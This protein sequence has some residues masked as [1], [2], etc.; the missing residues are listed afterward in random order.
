MVHAPA[1]TA[2]FSPVSYRHVKLDQRYDAI[3]IGSGAGGLTTAVLLAKHAHMRVLV[4]ERHYTAGGFTH[5]FRRPGFEW[6]VGVHY[7]GQTQTGSDGRR[8]F[9]HLTDARLQWAP[10]PDVYDRIFI[11]DRCYDFLSGTDRFRE[12]LKGYFPGDVQAIDRYVASV[13]R[14]VRLVGGFFAEKM[15]PPV[16]SRILGQALRWPYLRYAGRTT[17]SVIG[18]LTHNRELISVLTG[19]WGD[20]GLPPGQSSF[21]IHAILAKHYFDG[22]GYPVGGA[23]AILDSMG[24]A[25]QNAGGSVVVGAEVD[26]I[27]VHRNRTEGVRMVDGR[28]IR[29]NVVISDAGAGNTYYRLLRANDPALQRVRESI[30]RIPP[31]TGHLCL[32]V[33][34]NGTA[35]DLRLEGTNL[36][37]YPNEDH[38]ANVK[39]FFADPDSTLPIVYIS[40]P[41]A[42]DP[43]FQDRF[44]GRSTIDVITMA[45]YQWFSRWDQTRWHKRGADYDLFKEKLA[46]RLLEVLYRHVPTVRDRVVHAELSTPLSTRHF[47]NYAHGEIYGLAHTPDRFRLRRLGPRTPVRNLYLSGQD[48]S[49]CGVMGAVMGGIL[50][51]SLVLKRNM[52]GVV[53][54]K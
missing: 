31:S 33:G 19:Q 25:I 32:Y 38:D 44:P 46:S 21:G 49:V 51:A 20:Y 17:S 15:L 22:G 40:F 10:M 3:V 41:S 6:D 50:A 4:L 47:A 26:S 11:G 16:L 28:E 9:D 5:T 7:I 37:V 29:A 2:T 30:A 39:R 18:E 45:P 24:P 34:L 23:G 54:R 53:T 8:I 13:E 27:L 12:R 42:K 43:A 14:T 48:V 35:A 52:F 1:M 36:W